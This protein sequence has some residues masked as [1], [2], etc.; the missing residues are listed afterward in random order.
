[1]TKSDA[2]SSIRGAPSPWAEF[3]FENIIFTVPSCL[4]RDLEFPLDV[5]KLWNDILKAVADLAAIPHKFTR[6][7]RMVADVQIAAGKSTF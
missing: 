4:I 5:E 2:W 7:E 1:M 3:E 6:K